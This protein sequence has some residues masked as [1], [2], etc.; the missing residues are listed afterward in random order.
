M[1]ELDN[2]KNCD[3]LFV[4]TTS[5]VCPDCLKQEEKKFQ[6]VYTF[7]RKR[8]NRQATVQQI[9]EGTGVEEELILKFVKER[10]LRASQFPN[11][12]YPCEKCGAMIQDGKLCSDCSQEIAND[13][14]FQE[15]IDQ[16]QA[17]NE[18]S[19]REKART[20]Y[21]IDRSNK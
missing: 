2:C 14:A 17:R 13:L 3:K 18:E 10:R 8:V 21:T 5:D 11:L 4:R 20:Y 15:K 9:V 19:D 6:I 12:A 16:V 7:M 1:G